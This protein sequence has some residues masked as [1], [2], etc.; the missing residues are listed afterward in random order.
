MFKRYFCFLIVLVLL[1]TLVGCGGKDNDVASNKIEVS[2]ID[3]AK[4]LIDEGKIEEAYTLLYEMG[5][6]EEAIKLR[7]DFLIVHKEYKLIYPDAVETHRITYDKSGNALKK[8]DSDGNIIYERTYD[9]NNNPL[10]NKTYHEG[11]L[12]EIY[13]YEY[14]GNG[15]VYRAY[16]TDIEKHKH[17][18]F[19]RTYNTDGN[20]VIQT[21]EEYRTDFTYDSSG[22]LI[23]E[24]TQNEGNVTTVENVYDSNGNIIK[25]VYSMDDIYSCTTQYSYDESGNLTYKASVDS[26]DEKIEYEYAYNKNNL[27]L[28][29][30]CKSKDYYSE[31]L[32][33]YDAK[34]REIKY[35]IMDKKGVVYTAVS[36]YDDKNNTALFSYMPENEEN[37]YEKVWYDK[38]GNVIKRE[39]TY[40]DGAEG[41]YTEEYSGYMYFY[42]P[43]LKDKEELLYDECC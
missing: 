20:I 7:E 4:A 37:S 22:R 16:Y 35:V 17:L 3:L 33:T 24:V 11:G 15:R 41:S 8:V 40:E 36:S 1:V 14:D 9:E 18:T 42:R 30:K 10:T 21:G 6:D 26:D 2:K 25:S 34:G 13:E 19:K 27:L 31:E 32:F 38:N 12:F 5:D 29:E 39:L 23:K 28:M 43:D